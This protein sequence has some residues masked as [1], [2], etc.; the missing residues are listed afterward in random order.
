MFITN[1]S[2]AKAN[3]SR[4]IREVQNGKDVIIGKAGR[5]IATISAYKADLSPRKLGGSWEGKVRISEDFNDTPEALMEAFY[6]S[7]INPDHSEH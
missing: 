1:I 4:L 6:N 7:A 5:P 2:D 3:L